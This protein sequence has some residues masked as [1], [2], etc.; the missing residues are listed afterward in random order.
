MDFENIKELINIINSS[1]LA[2]FELKSNDDYIKMDKSLTRTSDNNAEKKEASIPVKEEA[3]KEKNDSKE[4]KSKNTVE[5]VI[6]ENSLIITSP[7]VGTFYSSPSPDS[8]AF[9]KEG[10]YVKKGKVICIIEAMKLMNE[11]ESNYDGNIVK[12]FVKDGDMIEFGQK[13]FEIKED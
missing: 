2:Y 7:M 1:D 13:L 12:C 6:D 11:I 9:V 4:N 8:E 10:D 5:E 3:T